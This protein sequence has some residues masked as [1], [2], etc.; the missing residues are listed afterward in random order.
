[1]CLSEDKKKKL[2]DLLAKQRAA[3]TGTSLS[4]TLAP[5]TSATPASHPPNPAPTTGELRGVLAVESD[6]EDTCTGLVFKRPRVGAYAVP[7]AS[8]SAGTPTFID[9]PLS[10]S[11]PFQLL[12]WRVGERVPLEVRRRTPTRGV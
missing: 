10:A 7:S 3:A 4:I 8:V 6:D 2:A 12:P 5:S 1:M 9:H 11:S